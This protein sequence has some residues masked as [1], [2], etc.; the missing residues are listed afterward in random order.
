MPP[1]A[2]VGNLARDRVDG[3]PPRIGGGPYY[4]ARA[5]RGLGS[6][7]TIYTRCGPEERFDYVRKLTALG[8]PVVSL[9]GSDTTSF[10]FHYEGSV[11]IMTVE[12]LGNPW[13]PDDA[14][15]LAPGA[16]VHVAPLLRSD[17]PAETLAAIARGRR[18]RSTARD[19]SAPPSWA[20][21]NSMRTSIPRCS[22]TCRSSSWQR[23]R[24][25]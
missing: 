19:S 23:R 1:L 20:R 10:S 6:R 18:L 3:S 4:A 7:A 9:E 8:L 25:R 2:L 11:R 5:W 15:I 22:S 21:S 13:T 14:E 17:F 16:W 24:P 12:H